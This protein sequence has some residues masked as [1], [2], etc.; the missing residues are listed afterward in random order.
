MDG[1]PP[2]PMR[3]HIEASLVLVTALLLSI[4][5]ARHLVGSFTGSPIKQS[6]SVY[7]DQDGRSTHEDV[8]KFSTKMPKFFT[9]AFAAIGGF[10]SIYLSV[11]DSL[12]A[13]VGIAQVAA[14]WTYSAT[15]I[16]LG[17]NALCLAACRVSTRAYDL[18]I[19]LGLAASILFFTLLD[20]EFTRAT[21]ATGA[22]QP[23]SIALGGLHILSALGL[24]I[25]AGSLQRRPKVYT[26]NGRPIDGHLT[27]S[28]IERVTY[29]WCRGILRLAGTKKDL[30]LTDFPALDHHT[31]SAD[32]AAAWKNHPA[33]P[34]LWRAVFRAHRGKL[35]QQWILAVVK[36]VINYAPHFFVLKFLETIERG[37]VHGRWPVSAWFLV[38]AILLSIFMDGVIEGWM[39]WLSFGE[40][41]VPLKA[42]LAALVVEKSMRRKNVKGVAD[43]DNGAAR[44]EDDALDSDSTPL[45]NPNGEGDGDQ[46]ANND[47]DSDGADPPQSR[48]A[49]INLIGVD[50]AHVADFAADQFQ[51]IHCASKVSTSLAFQAYLLGWIP[52]V[53]GLS[54]GIVLFPITGY[55]SRVYTKAQKRMMK[56]RDEQLQVV[57]ETLQGARQIKLSALEEQWEERILATRGKVLARVWDTFMADAAL[58][59]CWI[60]S[61]LAST[62]AALATYAIVN[63]GLTASVAFV[64]VAVFKSLESSL[65]QFPVLISDFLDAQVSTNRIEAYLNG[66]EIKPV[67]QDGPDVV[68]EGASIAWPID[69]ETPEAARFILR[70]I[71]L[72]FPRGE[73]SVISG[74]TGSG[75]SLLISSIIEEVDLLDG[76]IFAPTAPPVLERHDHKANSGNWIIPSV[77]A[78]V[79]QIPWI[80]NGSLRDNILFGLPLNEERYRETIEACAL[81]KDLEMLSDGDLTELGTNGIN[82]SGGQKWRVTLA[83]AVYSRAGILVLDDIFSAVDAHVGRHIFE[84]CLTGSLCRGRTRILVTHHVSLCQSRAKFLVELGDGTVLNSRLLDDLQ[85]DGTEALARTHEEPPLEIGSEA[86]TVNIDSDETVSVG[87]GN[88]GPPTSVPSKTP[89][90]FIEEERI[91]KGSVKA[92]IY[93][94]YLKSSGGFTAWTVAL[95][96]WIA[97]QGFALGRAYWLK[98]WTGSEEPQS[99]SYHY[100]AEMTVQP[101]LLSVPQG[102]TYTTAQSHS[103][104]YYLAIYIVISVSTG[105]LDILCF[106]YNY[107]LSIKA[108]KIL[109][110][111]ITYAVLRTP[112]RWLDT[113]PLG[114]ILNR[115]TA[116]FDTIDNQLAENMMLTV[117]SSLDAFRVCIAATLGT[118]HLLA[119]TLL[120]A[121]ACARIGH[122]YLAAGRPTRRLESNARSPM[123]E[124]YGAVL[125]GVA[126]IRS[127]GL[128]TTYLAK[129]YDHLDS[130]SVASRH[131]ALFNRWLSFWMIV[132]GTAFAGAAGCL[133]LLSDGMSA[134]LAGF[135]MSFA[136]NFSESMR[137]AVRCYL[138]TELDMN[139]A[140]RVIEY[141]TLKTEDLGGRHPP[142]A[143]P[144][145]G[146]VEVENL[147]VAYADDLPPVLRG[148]SF[149]IDGGERVGVVGRTGAGKSSL[150][151]ALFRL[152]EA[153]EGTI[154]IDGLDISEMN[155]HDLRSRLAIIPQD[156]VLFSGT[157]RSNLDP[158]NNYTDSELYDSL[159]RVHLLD[160]GRSSPTTSTA[161]PNPPQNI[162][163]NLSHPIS[164]GGGNLSQGQRQLL[165]LARAVTSRAGLMILDE[166]TSS[167]D[168]GAD[169]LIQQSIREEFRGSTLIVIAHR[170]STIADFDKIL[171]LSGGEVAEVGTPRELWSLG[172]VFRGMCEESGESEKLERVVLGLGG[173][174]D[175][176]RGKDVES[177]EVK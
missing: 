83:R 85:E 157:I 92:E 135:T 128:A 110:E 101:S 78:Y 13:R 46:K 124:L 23:L 158:F 49:I 90:Q 18:G 159:S 144:T 116:D 167:V 72:S 164:E 91:E 84:K 112:L 88:G 67:T 154:R 9:I 11:L 73:L 7:E 118:R 69:E 29:S 133:I 114:R 4:P 45:L 104:H 99:D 102:S 3:L 169:A 141:T 22:A 80:E 61:P 115:F 5:S 98:I 96:L 32:L 143:W 10:T 134:A 172:G 56:A 39:Y 26:K 109:F 14:I 103:L 81:I 107:W 161:S 156:P 126:T 16:V 152:L 173:M 79:A 163:S 137:W 59:S 1:S 60:I 160:S 25:S 20:L 82:L 36:G 149:S 166:A 105:L 50:T 168:M 34:R 140:E 93:G 142:A 44:S 130:Y 76:K 94:A 57:N 33:Q 132:M 146:R 176:W 64:G 42:Q 120:L 77:K 155:L 89:R 12:D 138:H 65:S 6:E 117:D 131:L 51:F 55:L 122:Q 68:F 52:V 165:C 119:P 43:L 139:A 48:Q 113:V 153:R 62:T 66:P 86:T 8:A 174:T 47:G 145:E 100:V 175:L 19:W 28:V 148:V 125:L 71:N 54:V 87:G 97:F 151:L 40:I 27:V 123:F 17:L 171:V 38:L 58:F 108:S 70:D 106:F 170:L 37:L 74:K 24:A 129:M 15:W 162:F 30:D 75:K 95:L 150:T 147:V 31:R 177:S 63:Q 53:A 21:N 136:I 111:K 2:L 127:S 35:S 121:G 41:S